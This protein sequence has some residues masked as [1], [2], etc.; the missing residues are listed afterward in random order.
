MAVSK[1]VAIPTLQ[2]FTPMSNRG[3]LPY[4]TVARIKQEEPVSIPMSL[5]YYA[6]QPQRWF[7]FEFARHFQAVKVVENEATILESDDYNT[8]LVNMDKQRFSMNE[9]Y[10]LMYRT[11]IPKIDHVIYEAIRPDT[12]KYPTVNITLNLGFVSG[13]ELR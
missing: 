10:I 9:A 5:L 1:F 3:V 7:D 4:L 2:V 8:T 6:G 13:L 12:A 11:D